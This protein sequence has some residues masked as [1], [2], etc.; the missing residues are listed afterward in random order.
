MHLI[1]VGDFI[2]NATDIL[3]ADLFKFKLEQQ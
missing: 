3:Y 1:L 2:S